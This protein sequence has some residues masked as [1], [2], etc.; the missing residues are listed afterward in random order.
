MYWI[1]TSA[2]GALVRQTAAPIAPKGALNLDSY[3]GHNFL[4]VE[5]EV[6]TH[7]WLHDFRSRFEQPIFHFEN[8]V[9]R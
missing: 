7:Y 6:S 3:V 5:E 4:I 2:N 8:G 1:D 9:F